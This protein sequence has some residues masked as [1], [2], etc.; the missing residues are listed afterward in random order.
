MKIH[1]TNMGR[2]TLCGR[3][4]KTGL[5]VFVGVGRIRRY[6]T[7]KDIRELGKSWILKH[8]VEKKPNAKTKKG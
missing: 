7:H 4:L 6:K 5:R 2:F 8:C 1:V 3:T